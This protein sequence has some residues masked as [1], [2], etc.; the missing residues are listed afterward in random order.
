VAVAPYAWAQR[1]AA[2]ASEGSRGMEERAPERELSVE[3]ESSGLGRQATSRTETALWAGQANH[4][5][6]PPDLK[7]PP[8]SLGLPRGACVLSYAPWPR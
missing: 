1:A 4:P 3:A 6:P 7:Q 5:E 8:P 2:E